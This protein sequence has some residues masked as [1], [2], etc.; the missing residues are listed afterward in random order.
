MTVCPAMF[1]VNAIHETKSKST[2]LLCTESALACSPSKEE[3]FVEIAKV[4][5]YDN[6]DSRKSS[7]TT[8]AEE[9]RGIH[10]SKLTA[11]STF[12][13]DSN[14]HLVLQKVEE[15]N[16]SLQKIPQS[17]V[18]T[19]SSPEKLKQLL[20]LHHSNENS[21][22]RPGEMFPYLHGATAIREKVYFDKRFD[23]ATDLPLLSEDDETI[24]SIFAPNSFAKAPELGF[25]LMT[26]NSQ[27]DEMPRLINSVVIEDLLTFKEILDTDTDLLEY[28]N[29][30]Q[31]T[32]ID[33]TVHLSCN[34]LAQTNRNFLLQIKLM[35]PIS[36][37]LVYN[38]DMNISTNIDVA[39][40]IDYLRGFDATRNIY[41]VDFPASEWPQLGRY[42]Q[43]PKL[44]ISEKYPKLGPSGRNTSTNDLCALEQNLVWLVYNM[45][46]LFPRLYVGN[47]LSFKQIISSPEKASQYDFQ[48]Y[49]YCHEKAQMPSMATLGQTLR[50]LESGKLQKPVFLEF[51]DAVLRHGSSLSKED[52][53]VFLNLL[54]VINL[55]VNKGQQNVLVYSYDGFTGTSLLLLGLGLFWGCDHIEEVALCLFRKPEVKFHLGHGDFSILKNLEL[56]IQWFKRQPA[57]D[58][59]LL[60][61]LPVEKIYANYRPYIRSTD[62]FRTDHE[63]NFPAYIY[64][65]LFLGSV[66]HASS[67]TVLAAL[68]VT[69]VISIGE[70]P[71]WFAALRGTFSHEVTPQTIGPIIEP[72]YRFNN[73]RSLVYEVKI[74]S[75]AMRAHLFGHV[76]VPQLKSF[77]YIHGLEDDGRDLM[78][79]LL[80]GC[81]EWIQ[82]KLLVSPGDHDKTLVHCRIGVSRSATL[83]VASVMRNFHMSLVESFLYVRVRRFNVVIQPNLRLF[84]ELF[85]YDAHLQARRPN[86]EP[87]TETPV[88][89]WTLCTEIHRLNQQ[90]MG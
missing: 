34:P 90:Y 35:A 11:E 44:D 24:S 75:P 83:A 87:D 76:P 54:R 8:L 46:Q 42:K 1:A 63:I 18:Y 14:L 69:K 88:C 89:W 66:S 51:S 80:V 47:V 68:H 37:F 16:H 77:I 82:N 17:N 32:A 85:L 23:P 36:H 57:K 38:N 79:P 2:Q 70:M 72:I 25:H 86:I 6:A 27:A 15:L 29:I 43:S 48:L 45:N 28:T 56:H 74:T 13:N 67:V 73:G 62:W 81:P 61:E 55:I 41:V 59:G 40:I 39:R 19:I 31:F 49:V 3:V 52:T 78:F 58:N 5:S 22:P 20:D 65:N 9:F 64:E 4:K 50:E 26:V 7:D 60:I 10:L 21:M 33:K 84:Y 12:T 53:L 71:R 30:Q